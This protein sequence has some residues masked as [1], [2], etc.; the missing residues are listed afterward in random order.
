M[1]T[2]QAS[3]YTGANGSRGFFM[4]TEMVRSNLQEW[5]SDLLVQRRQFAMLFGVNSLEKYF[6]K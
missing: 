1:T 3:L 5:L 4:A 2:L 6:N